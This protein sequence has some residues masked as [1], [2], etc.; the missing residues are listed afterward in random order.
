MAGMKIFTSLLC[1][2]L[3]VSGPTI[4]PQNTPDTMEKSPVF[5]I[6]QDHSV[7]GG[8]SLVVSGVYVPGFDINFDGVFD[9]TD[10]ELI[11]SARE[12]K[13]IEEEEKRQQQIAAEEKVAKE[14][15]ERKAAE[16][17]STIQLT[18]TEPPVMQ[19]P[20]TAEQEIQSLDTEMHG[21]DVSRW[22]GRIDWNR[23]KAAGV[24]F[25][26]IKAG[27]GTEVER[28]FYANINGAKEAGVYC[29]VYWFSNAHTYDEAIAEANA[30]LEVISQ[31]QLEF[32]VVC[33]FEYRSLKNNPLAD[34]RK[35]LTDALIGFLGTIEN[36]GF[37]SMLYTNTD[38]SG[39]YLEFSR[40]TEKYDIWFAGYSVDK[41]GMPCGIWQY[42]ETGVKD[43]IDIDN[44]NVGQTKVDLDI[45]YKNYPQIMKDLHINGY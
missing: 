38:F 37:Y 12:K 3:A 4:S 5:P 34:S 42:S 8:S 29:G 16:E 15:A 24:E 27:E 10:V 39:K 11:K 18:V 19:S 14:E 6:I 1:S 17:A 2:A 13:R 30:C 23:L 32:P 44:P 35:D 21:V 22:Q 36:N 40:I 26:M 28:N 43:G 7:E 41:P 45:A 31:Y 20:Q 9:S 25:A 33:D